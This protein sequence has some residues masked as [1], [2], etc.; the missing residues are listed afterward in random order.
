MEE[1]IL[2]HGVYGTVVAC[3][4]DPRC[5][6]KT[7]K[8]ADASRIESEDVLPSLS[9]GHPN[10]AKVFAV[11]IDED[12]LRIRMRRYVGDVHQYMIRTKHALPLED[13]L[14]LESQIGSALEYLHSLHILHGDVKPENVLHDADMHFFLTDFSISMELDKDKLRHSNQIYTYL[15]RPPILFYCEAGHDPIPEYDFYALFFT[16]CFVHMLFQIGSDFHTNF[17]LVHNAWAFRE[18]RFDHLVK[19]RLRGLRFVEMYCIAFEKCF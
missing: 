7:I 6:I 19:T 13:T 9:S 16:V 1:D 11:A 18:E 8:V 2:G 15:F 17:E 5:A 14:R 10:L 12:L 3:E 4:K